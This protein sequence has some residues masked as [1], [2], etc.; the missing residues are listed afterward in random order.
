[1]LGVKR[2]EVRLEEHSEQWKVLF[3]ETEAEI[4]RILGANVMDVQHIGSTAIK[5][6]VAKPILDVAVTVHQL[7]AIDFCGMEC[8]GYK[9]RG[10]AGVPGRSYFAKYRDEEITTHHIHCYEQGNSNLLANLAFRDFLIANPVYGRQYS[11]LKLYL[12]EQYANDRATYTNEKTDFI[13]MVLQLA[14]FS[15]G[16]QG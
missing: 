3:E 16:L 13:H 10:E 4:R 6:I 5:G 14:G 9:S 11:D 7:T 15:A 8:F 1:M 2:Y 12:A